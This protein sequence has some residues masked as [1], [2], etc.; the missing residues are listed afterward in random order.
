MI[1]EQDIQ[2]VLEEFMELE[3]D[4]KTVN[5]DSY[6]GCYEG[7]YGYDTGVMV[8]V[9]EGSAEADGWVDM[10]MV[11]KE[12]MHMEVVHMQDMMEGYRESLSCKILFVFFCFIV[13]ECYVLEW[14]LSLGLIVLFL[15]V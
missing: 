15:W 11:M 1:V 9:I 4:M 12:A 13:L 2:E 8:M 7:G 14:S 6:W 10:D 5:G 3:M